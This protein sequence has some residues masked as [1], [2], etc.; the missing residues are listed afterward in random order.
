MLELLEDKGDFRMARKKKVKVV[1]YLFESEVV[2]S[3]LVPDMGVKFKGLGSILGYNPTPP[4]RSFEGRFSSS[5]VSDAYWYLSNSPKH[6]DF[7]D[8]NNT[9]GLRFSDS[10]YRMVAEAQELG[11][12]NDFYFCEEPS[13][14][15]HSTGNIDSEYVDQL[16]RTLAMAESRRFSGWRNQSHNDYLTTKAL[17]T[18]E[19]NKNTIDQL[20]GF[21]R[22][23]DDVVDL[24]NQGGSWHSS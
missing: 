6:K 15:T 24:M 20:V 5:P 13:L 8:P 2:E 4:H 17:L 22:P 12:E 14:F 23:T 10:E 21:S 9:L 19:I 3:F 16:K 7:F 18:K 11:S 1:E